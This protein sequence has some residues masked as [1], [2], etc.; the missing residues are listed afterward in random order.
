MKHYWGRAT[1]GGSWDF[2]SYGDW[3]EKIKE[4]YVPR[5]WEENELELHGQCS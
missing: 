1:N 4:N 5:S 2:I 3:N